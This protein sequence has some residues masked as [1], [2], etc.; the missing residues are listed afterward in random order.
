MPGKS[1]TLVIK[2]LSDALGATKGL[3]QTETAVGRAQQ[4]VEGL[5]V[6]AGIALGG[7]LALGK[8]TADAA[9][10][11]EQSMGALE[12]VF[13]D[14]SDA[15]KAFA[16]DSARATGLATSDYAQMAATLGAQLKNLGVPQDQILQQ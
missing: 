6:P 2:I 9:S 13:K 7:I 15:A 8:G 14:Q 4:K 3:Q 16:R 11:V 10:E 5:A 1:A 12:A